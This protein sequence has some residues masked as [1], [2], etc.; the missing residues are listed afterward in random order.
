MIKLR[1]EIVINDKL[2]DEDVARN[3]VKYLKRVVGDRRAI[4]SHVR[5]QLKGED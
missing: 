4:L 5:E 1:I 2:S 3:V